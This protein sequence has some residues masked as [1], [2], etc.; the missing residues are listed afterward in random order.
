MRHK[1]LIL[2][3]FFMSISAI[4]E[5]N[6]EK[7]V[8]QISSG[9]TAEKICRKNAAPAKDFFLRSEKAFTCSTLHDRSYC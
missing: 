3:S 2:V 8:K 1:S 9:A 7:L 5:T 4:A 6:A